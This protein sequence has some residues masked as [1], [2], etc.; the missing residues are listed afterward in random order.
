MVRIW[1]FISITI[2]IICLLLMFHYKES[3]VE[4][5]ASL[6]FLNLKNNYVKV[7]K[8]SD[9]HVQSA[10]NKDKK[11][12]SELNLLYHILMSS[13]VS[14]RNKLTKLGSQRELKKYLER[15]VKLNKAVDKIAAM[16]GTSSQDEP[17]KLVSVNKT[18]NIIHNRINKAGSTSMMGKALYLLN[19]EIN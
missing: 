18:R 4:Q 16:L 9:E 6:V 17:E 2:I 8:S 11:L 10:S 12:S 19:F 14:E 5:N 3:S 15:H 1:L 13:K 7:T